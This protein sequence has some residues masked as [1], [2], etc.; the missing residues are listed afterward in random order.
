MSLDSPIPLHFEGEETD[1]EVFIVL[2]AHP[3]TNIGWVLATIFFILIALVTLLILFFSPSYESPFSFM[4]ATIAFAVW[5]TVVLGFAFQ[6]FLH[7]YFNL[8]ILT[9]RRIID[10]DFYG[11]FHRQI[12]QTHITHVQDITF[13]KSGILQ[14]FLDFGNM[15]LQTAGTE[16]NFEFN[17]IPDP[18]TNQKHIVSL[19]RK[20]KTKHGHDGL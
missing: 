12:S 5:V 13:T 16:A 4:T 1:E 9:S 10:I 19:I 18:E 14:N 20:Y 11:L 17:N 3:V 6:R 15:H 2:R 8:F 7:W